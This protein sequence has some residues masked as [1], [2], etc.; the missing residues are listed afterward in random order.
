M[1]KEREYFIADYHNTPEEIEARK[2]QIDEAMASVLKT[3]K[4]GKTW[5]MVKN[6]S[7]SGMS[8]N[9]LFYRVK[10]GGIE[11][12]TPEIAWLRGEVKPGKYTKGRNEFIYHG[13]NVGGCG[14]DMI[15]YTLYSCM[16]YKQASKWNQN[17]RTL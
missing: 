15:F 4:Q 11:N 17:Y 5:A 13:L 12:I 9:I 7:K 10:Q 14:M 16:P 2:K 3:I 6:V 1:K 8:R